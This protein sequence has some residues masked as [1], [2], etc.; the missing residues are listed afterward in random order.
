MEQELRE[1]LPTDG[2]FLMESLVQTEQRI[3][4]SHFLKISFLVVEVGLVLLVMD[5]ELEEKAVLPLVE[6]GVRQDTVVQQPIMVWKNLVEDG[7]AGVLTL[8]GIV[9]TRVGI[10]IQ[11]MVVK[12]VLEWL[13]FVCT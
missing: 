6:K 9:M 5:K 3:L 11:P 7:E 4:T 10:T 12:V 8:N 1:F 2:I 13:Q